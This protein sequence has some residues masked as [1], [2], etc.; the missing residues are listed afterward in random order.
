MK[1]IELHVGF[2]ASDGEP[3]EEEP[4][5]LLAEFDLLQEDDQTKHVY[6]C[7]GL[8]AY[9]A[10]VLEV[11]IKLVILGHARATGKA[12]TL[13]EFESVETAASTM[14]LGRLVREV[15]ALVNCD[16]LTVD[17]L[18][19]ALDRRN[20]LIHD[21]F[22]IHAADF[23][24]IRGRRQMVESL[25]EGI[26]LFRTA[27]APVDAVTSVLMDIIGISREDLSRMYN[28]MVTRGE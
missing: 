17:V 21:F 1:R 12:V 11:G 2:A 22:E 18:T 20:H 7:F 4:C 25:E 14:T 9:W 8:A 16:E 19:R 15:R 5:P 28:E 26:E 3:E 10:Q 13:A 24:T 23:M 6:A 27:N